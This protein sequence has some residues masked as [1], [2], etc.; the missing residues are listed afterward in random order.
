MA[1]NAEHKPDIEQDYRWTAAGRL[2]PSWTATSTLKSD[3]VSPSTVVCPEGLTFSLQVGPDGRRD[4]PPDIRRRAAEDRLEELPSEATWIWS[5]GSASGGIMDGGRG[6]T[7]SFPS[8]DTREVRVAAGSLCS[9]TR[10]ELFALRVALEE[11]SRV[12]TRADSLPVVLCTDSMA[13]LAGNGAALPPRERR[14]PRPSGSCCDRSPT[15]DSP[16]TCS[17]FPPTAGCPATSGQTPS[18]GRPTPYRSTRPA[19]TPDR[20]EGRSEICYRYMAEEL[21]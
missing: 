11:L 15:E 9:S 19:S 7:V 13:A 1:I 2:S 10:A 3:S 20:P 17:G 18:P 5:V 21:A 12:D 16:S 8:G 4:R 14:W 6:A